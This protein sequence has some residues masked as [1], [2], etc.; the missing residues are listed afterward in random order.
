M[1]IP[2]LISTEE[3]F[4]HRYFVAACTPHPFS[5]FRVSNIVSTNGHP[6]QP[7][8]M[9]SGLVHQPT[10]VVFPLPRHCSHPATLSPPCHSQKVSTTYFQPAVRPASVLSRF[11]RF[12]PIG[13]R[14]KG[15][16]ALR[17]PTAHTYIFYRS[18]L[19][20]VRRG[21]QFLR[22]FERPNWFS[23][24]FQRFL[25][26]QYK[27]AVLSPSKYTKTLL[28]NHLGFQIKQMRPLKASLQ[29]ARSNLI[30]PW[31]GPQYFVSVGSVSNE[32][33]SEL[34]GF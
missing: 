34:R 25:K 18:C 10:P 6:L 15:G 8:R 13:P 19:F 28:Y 24:F 3:L 14:A 22:F 1:V 5:S 29:S 21:A 31:S 26:I 12:R 17:L 23:N 30:K 9:R 4:S 11:D 32:N 16:P 20:I 27:I 7:S 33:P 2:S